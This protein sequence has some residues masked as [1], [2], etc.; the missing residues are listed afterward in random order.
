MMSLLGLFT[1]TWKK[2]DVAAQA[3]AA[4]AALRSFPSLVATVPDPSRRRRDDVQQGRQGGV[5]CPAR[6]TQHA[7][8]SSRRSR[9]AARAARRS[10]LHGSRHDFLRAGVPCPKSEPAEI[11]GLTRTRKEWGVTDGLPAAGTCREGRL[12]SVPPLRHPGR[13]RAV[14]GWRGAVERASRPRRSCSAGSSTR[15]NKR[16][17]TAWATRPTRSPSGSW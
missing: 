8:G 9:G 15:R 5:P 2:N 10:A 3:T 17:A 14:L 16:T 1:G 6:R 13:C 11:S 7:C 12:P 4:P